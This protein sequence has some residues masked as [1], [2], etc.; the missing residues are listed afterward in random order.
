MLAYQYLKF[1]LLGQR[2]VISFLSY[3]M[4]AVEFV[5]GFRNVSI[6]VILNKFQLVIK[7]CYENRDIAYSSNL[8]D[9]CLS[10]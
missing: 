7:F 10:E 1:S 4:L 2:N 3:L 5:M 9:R 6:I 8:Y